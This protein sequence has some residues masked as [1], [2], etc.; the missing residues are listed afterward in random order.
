M[1]FSVFCGQDAK[2]I[3]QADELY[4]REKDQDMLI[5]LVEKY[6]DKDYVIQIGSEGADWSLISACNQKIKG[7]VYCALE[8][9]YQAGECKQYNLPFFYAFPVTSFFELRGLK[10]LGVSYVRLGIPI[11][12]QTKD[13][14]T[15]NIPVRLTPNKAY[16]AYIPRE[17]G[18]A[19]Q[20]IRPEDLDLYD[21][22]YP[23]A[24][25]EF[26]TFD[27]PLE[28]NHLVYE[29]T[30]LDIYKNQKRWDG[31]LINIIKDIGVNNLNSMVDAD[32]G[33]HRLNC[34][35]VC[36]LGRCHYCDRAIKFDEVV[37][38]YKEIK[39]KRKSESSEQ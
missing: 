14:A 6:P 34:A 25:C 33:K 11:F 7:T 12:F 23:N 5:D 16:E 4:L 38:K 20:W 3:A 36:Q 15:F 28:G 2:T 29:R 39:E 21:K 9:I 17:D 10:N 26:R 32:I 24:I 22:A 13:V 1:R 18:V 30:L 19:G 27:V 8:N 35:Q 31:R 37:L